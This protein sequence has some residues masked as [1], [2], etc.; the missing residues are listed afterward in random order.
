MSLHLTRPAVLTET[1]NNEEHITT[2][3]APG[4]GAVRAVQLRTCEH[5]RLM[6]GEDAAIEPDLGLPYNE[7]RGSCANAKDSGMVESGACGA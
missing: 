1:G 5:Y 4:Y 7:K 6:T 2:V 3:I